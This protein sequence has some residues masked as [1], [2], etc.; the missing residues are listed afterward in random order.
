MKLNVLFLLNCE[1]S[2]YIAKLFS[3]SILNLLRK[4][5]KMLGKP[6]ILSLFPNLFHKFNK[7]PELKEDP[8]FNPITLWSLATL[9]AI[10]LASTWTVPMY[11]MYG[12]QQF[13]S[14]EI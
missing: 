12:E 3:L 9:S 13:D 2:K 8:L 11:Y 14:E 7:T 4:S 1:S 10:G 6:R 5:D